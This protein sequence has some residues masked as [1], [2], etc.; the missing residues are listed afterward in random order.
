MNGNIDP[1]E[2]TPTLRVRVYESL[3]RLIIEGALAPGEHLV[4]TEL[5]T[6]LGVSRGPVR[7]ALQTLSQDGWVELRPR[8]GAFVRQP[9]EREVDEFFQVRALLEGEC[10]RLAA[11]NIDEQTARGLR[12][13]VTEGW[14]AVEAGEEASL[15]TANARLHLAITEL[16]GNATLQELTQRLRKRSQ[17]FFTPVSMARAQDAW[18]EHEA[19]V[20]SIVAGDGDGASQR[21][22]DHVDGTHQTYASLLFESDGRYERAESG[23]SPPR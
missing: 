16:S 15:V 9:T 4:E 7:E 23:T 20:E 5:A 13:K 8:H 17:W 12:E 21:M 10:A 6:R 14:A 19:I 3:E 2:P 18:R 1:I 22:R 11:A